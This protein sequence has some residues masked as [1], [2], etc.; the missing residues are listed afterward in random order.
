MYGKYDNIKIQGIVSTV[1]VSV[2]DNMEWANEANSRR[3]KRQIKVTGVQRRHVVQ[4]EQRASDLAYRAA[5]ELIERMGVDLH[6]IKICI[7]VTQFP[8]YET[9]ST[10]FFL[11]KL[12][13]LDKECV[14]YDIN[15][16]CSGFNVGVQTV[17]AM[18]Q[19]CETHSQALLLQADIIGRARNPEVNYSEDQVA[20]D[21]LF[22]SAASAVLL[23][24]VENSEL[25][26]MNQSDGTGYQQ[27]IR[28]PGQQSMM[29]GAGVYNFT[30]NEVTQGIK[31]FKNIFNLNDENIDYYAFHQ[32]QALILDS[33]SDLC[34][35]P[36]EKELRSIQEYGN[37]SGASVPLT[38]CAN[39]EL[40]R[41]KGNC[42]LF[43]SGFGV[44]LSWGYVY[45][46]VNAENIFPIVETD[47]HY[48][49]E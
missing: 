37:T 23:E 16:G 33:I 11:H 30:V 12:L 42:R 1:P 35:I 46:S 20:H 14:V 44:G 36:P 3:V 41:K 22:G 43:L 45:T 25:F 21:M 38:L 47:E 4:S 27:I 24:K 10:A 2:E 31:R 13:G 7:F 34:G 48:G 8:N 6:N 29:D 40:L 39:Y 9:P 18:L 5:V 28:Y 32:A 49:D 15:L 26:F 17:S 19:T